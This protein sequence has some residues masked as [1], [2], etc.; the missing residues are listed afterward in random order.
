MK[1]Y[2]QDDLFVMGAVFEALRIARLEAHDSSHDVF[3]SFLDYMEEELDWERMHERERM[4]VIQKL[5]RARRI[6]T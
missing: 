5:K 3:E 1:T 6:A 2:G 4:Y